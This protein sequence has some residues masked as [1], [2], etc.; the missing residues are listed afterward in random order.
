MFAFY[1]VWPYMGL[2]AALLLALL[3]STDALRSDLTVSRWR[4]LVW[5]AW[6]GTL[7]YL[8]HQFEEH[9]IDAE[10]AT[11]TLQR[12]DELEVAHFGDAI[13]LKAG[14]DPVQR[15]LPPAPPRERPRQPPG[16]EPLRRT[17]SRG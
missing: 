8:I 16:R 1:L 17:R 14:A 11:Y 2:G 10:G 15:P 5:L 12:G 3:L 7:A 9:G 13:T 6:L 4:D